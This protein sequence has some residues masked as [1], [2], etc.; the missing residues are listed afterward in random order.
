LTGPLAV[1]PSRRRGRVVAAAAGGLLLALAFPNASLVPLMLPGVMGLLAALDGAP[2]REAALAGG[3]F[4][5]VFWLGTVPWIAFTVHTFGG[6]SWPLAVLALCLSALILTPPFA[7][8]GALVGLA[9]PST[10][11]GLALVFAAAWVVQEGIRVYLF[12]GFPW[13]LLCY[14]LAGTPELIQ[15]A[16]I[17][18]A[19][20]TSGLVAAVAGLLHAGI[21]ARDRSLRAVWTLSALVLVGAIALYGRV[22]LATPAV[23]GP[24]PA[25]HVGIVQPNT[26]QLQRWTPEVRERL[27]RDLVDQSATLVAFSAP[28]PDVVL[29]PESASPYS[30]PWSP[31]YRQDLVARAQQLG[32]GILL[33][34]VWTERPGDDD[35]PFYNAALLV[36]PAGPVLPPYFKLRLVP[37]GEYVPLSSIL[38][39]I[40]PISR[41]VPSS[42][43]PGTEARPIPWAG[44]RLGG[45]VCYEVVYPWILRAQVR[46]GA[47]VLF[48]LTNDAWYGTGGAQ[49]Q[50]WQAAVFRAVETGRPLVRA[51]ITGISG[52]VLPDGRSYPLLAAGKRGAFTVTLDGSVRETA[53]VSTV[54][55]GCLW[56]CAAGVLIAI[57]RRRA[58][59]PRT[60][61]AAIATGAAA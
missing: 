60:A 47:D 57:L 5:F 48:T 41:A 35:A 33:S 11:A 9:R 43:S 30:W 16:S 39:R 24:L 54:G 26:P 18:S 59:P 32:T 10:A 25:L 14:P 15:S 40:R 12:G 20:L 3:A 23:P 45:A 21:T 49:A 51:A 6:L 58:V 7:A 37:F 13:A 36:G 53:Y 55:D 31:G 29:W 2:P 46:A 19:L 28:R 38:S 1:L 22:R 52:Y 4:G 56:V 17:G 27:Y 50:H 44:R 61:A 34:T 8:L 42:F